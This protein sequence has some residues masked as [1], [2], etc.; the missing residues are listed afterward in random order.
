MTDA[1]ILH[2]S[3][4]L[5][6]P[7]HWDEALLQA[8]PYAQRLELARRSTEARRASLS[9]LGL[10]LMAAERIGRRSYSP[11]AFSFPED[12]KPV[13]RGGPRFSVS[14]TASRVACIA[15]LTSECGLDIEETG[16]HP[17]AAKVLQL[18]RW[19]ATEAALKA[20]GQGL[21]AAHEVV[22]GNTLDVAIVRDESF[23]L[24]A[25][26]AVPDCIGH[27]ASPAGLT[28]VVE[29]VDLAGPGISAALERSLGLP[30][31]FE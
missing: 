27:V 7:A 4:R 2:A 25:L 28:F 1:I 8:L 19:T 10:T 22:L 16:A 30:S 26:D 11:S 3:L 6:S 18:E 5:P 31:Q 29:T 20:A 24:Q 14:H 12:G 15:S 9:A 21:R 13:L 17:A 23:V